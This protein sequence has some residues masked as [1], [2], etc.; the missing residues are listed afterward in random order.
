MQNNKVLETGFYALGTRHLRWERFDKNG[1]LLAKTHYELGFPRDANVSYYGEDRS[2]IN[3]VVPYVNGKLEGEYAKFLVER[4]ARLARPVRERQARGRLDQVLGLPRPPPLR[5]PV[6]RVGLR[7]RGDRARA[8]P[9]VQPQRTC[10]STTR[11]KTTTTATTPKPK[12]A[13]APRAA[14]ATRP[15]P[16]TRPPAKCSPRSVDCSVC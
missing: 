4:A 7:P 5:V 14:P 8:H 10:S 3:E 13:P 12:T 16:P 11:R 2:L 9:A 1:I 15:A 6:R